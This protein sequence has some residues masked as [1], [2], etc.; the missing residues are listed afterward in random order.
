MKAQASETIRKEFAHIDALYFNT[1]YFGPSPY[2]AK[3]KVSNALFKELD[4]SFT[5]YNTWMGIPDRIRTQI[6]KL[7]QVSPDNIALQS[8]TTDVISIVANGYKLKSD[9]AVTT[10]NKEYPSNVLPWML[11]KKN[12]GINLNM[13]ETTMP[14]A[15][16]LADNLPKNTKI[17]NISFVTF[18]TG[19]KIDLISIGKLMKERDIFFIVDATQALGGMPITEEELQYID[20]L[21]CSC[22]KWLLG[23][24]GTAFAYFSDEAIK[25]IEHKTGNWIN[26]INSK[27]VYD[28]L[29]YTLETLPGARKFDRGQAPNMLANACLEASLELLNF[30]GLDEIEKHNHEIRNHFLD[31]FPKKKYELITPKEHMANIVCL[32][33]KNLDPVELE[34][35]LKHNLIDVS[36]RQGNIRL[37]FHLFNT[38]NQV[39]T[40]A[41]TLDI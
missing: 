23:P 5:A 6:A 25:K 7:L 24:Y 30:I 33:V 3:Q 28:L 29:N 15:E 4:P 27:N 37:S 41:Q 32:K 18:D 20:V 14:T 8:S 26:S 2:R 12:T 13:L 36:V 19:K 22:Y 17:F 39:D 1:A 9:E 31:I 11:L 38:K 34:R 35:E 21:S 40:L 16:W 10:L